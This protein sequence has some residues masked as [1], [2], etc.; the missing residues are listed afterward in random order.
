M[1]ALRL[2]NAWWWSGAFV[3]LLAL[4]SI[5][6]HPFGSVKESGRQEVSASD[7]NLSPQVAA[8]L[9]RSCMD[10]HSNRTMW[11]WYSYVA[12]MSWLVER[13]VGRGRDRLNLSLWHQ[14]TLSQQ[15]KLLADIASA[16]KNREMPLPQYTLV[17]RNARLSNA[18]TD[19]VYGWARVERRRLKTS[20][21]VVNTGDGRSANSQ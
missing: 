1:R 8:L 9:K 5:A 3:T 10:C 16:V 7:L 13:D 15:E 11:P 2:K 18:D 6:V 12:P 4:C 20:R 19:L 14:Y 17:H 21:P